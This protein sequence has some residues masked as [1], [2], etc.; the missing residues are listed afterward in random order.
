METEKTNSTEVKKNG[1][2][3][4]RKFRSI[5]I[6]LTYINV[7][8]NRP[9][10]VLLLQRKCK[11]SGDNNKH[12][13]SYIFCRYLQMRVHRHFQEYWKALI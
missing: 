8:P 1:K 2:G 12:K 3:Y 6:L 7:W 9:S 10:E 5:K 4:Y 13:L 11:R